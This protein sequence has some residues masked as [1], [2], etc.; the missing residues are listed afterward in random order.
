MKALPL[1]ALFALAGVAGTAAEAPPSAPYVTDALTW[2]S[3]GFAAGHDRVTIRTAD[4]EMSVGVSA[5]RLSA[6]GGLDAR[7]PDGPVRFEVIGEAGR[8]ACEGRRRGKRA[9]G[10][11]RFVSDPAFSIGLAQRGVKLKQRRTL[12]AL[13]LVDAHLALVDDLSRE[14]F[15]IAQASDLVASTALKI[16]G[17]YVRELKTAGLR[18]D[19]LNDLYAARALDVDGA[20]LRRMAEAGYPNLTANQAITMKAV[21]VTPA[22]ADA[23]N[24]AAATAHAVEGMGELQ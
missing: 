9:T 15:E 24:R 13:A 21:G 2:S 19:R 23:M 14:G 7:T 16:T 3:D 17:D 20:F 4:G 5:E 8:T 1:I 11:C 22:Y 6:V 18:L 12:I 10:T